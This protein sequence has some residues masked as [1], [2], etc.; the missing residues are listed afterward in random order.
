MTD[1][2]KNRERW[3][4]KSKQ[5]QKK[6]TKLKHI[7]EEKENYEKILKKNEYVFKSLFENAAIG[8]YRTTTNGKL[9]IA[10]DALVR[11]LGYSSLSEIPEYPMKDIY[12][13]INDRARFIKKALKDGKVIGFETEFRKKDGTIFSVRMN[14]SLIK[15][16]GKKK[17]YLEGTIEDIT[18]KIIAENQL[19]AAKEKAEEMNKL[20]GNFLAIM[21]HELRTPLV[22]IL[23]FAEI[24]KNELKESEQIDMAESIYNSGRRLMDTLNSLLDYSRLEAQKIEINKKQHNVSHLVADAVRSFT[25]TAERNNL[26]LNL[27]IIDEEIKA[28]LDAHIFNNIIFNLLNNAIKYT[29]HGGVIVEVN[30]MSEGKNRYAIIKIKD[31]GIGISESSRE[32]IFEEFRQA[33][34]GIN[35]QYE[36]SGLGL[37]ITKRYVELLGGK[38]Y[39]K[40]KIGK[41]STFILKFPEIKTKPGKEK[42]NFNKKAAQKLNQ[43][44]NTNLPN[45]LLVDNDPV[46]I[47]VAKIILKNVCEIDSALNSQEALNKVKEREFD[48]V[49]MDIN[50]GVGLNGLET[51][52]EIRK[53]PKYSQTPIVAL[54]AYALNGDREKFLQGGCT[55]YISKPFDKESLINLMNNILHQQIL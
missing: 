33:S 38:I 15:S 41:G 12:K 16:K 35:R 32:I 52:K 11:M 28:S 14:T 36:G 9:L 2:K 31:S 19:I 44:L 29:E 46:A 51:T 27:K 23:G 45:V 6:N 4:A 25:N 13:N 10:N 47:G 24:F 7:I 26:Y 8:I 17:I 55:H 21:S 34:E 18:E 43:S 42:N 54:T 40:S 20:K 37:T 50:L 49:L 22:G 39:L 5:L 30:S 53:Y 1:N 3:E 48:A